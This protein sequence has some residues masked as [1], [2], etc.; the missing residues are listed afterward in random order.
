[1][2]IEDKR[3]NVTDLFENYGPDELDVFGLDSEETSVVIAD[4]VFFDA[5][6]CAKLCEALVEC[7][8]GTE[9]DIQ[10]RA[11]FVDCCEAA[12]EED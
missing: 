9:V 10:I 5:E 8:C 7:G 6:A 12:T 11:V 1:M 2:G 3:K 4:A